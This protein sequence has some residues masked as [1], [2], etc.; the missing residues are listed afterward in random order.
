MKYTLD[1]ADIFD[2]GFFRDQNI[3]MALPDRQDF[4][5]S[6]AREHGRLWQQDVMEW[7]LRYI[8]LNPCVVDVG[9]Y[10]GNSAIWLARIAGAK[11]VTAIEP[12]AWSYSLLETNVRLNGLGKVIRTVNAA[13]WDE[14][15]TACLRVDSINNHA[16]AQ[17]RPVPDGVEP[18]PL[19]SVPMV[20]IDSVMADRKGKVNLLLLDMEGY[21]YRAI[22][23]ARKLV[24]SDRPVLMVTTFH[25]T[26]KTL[27]PL[28][29]SLRGY[30]YLMGDLAE[31]GYVAVG[32]SFST[33][34]Y[35]PKE[36][37]ED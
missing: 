18:D 5:Q 1:N 20:T 4:L 11:S 7:A 17:Y 30:I 6:F 16:A 27:D 8:P 29:D 32:K 22:R 23:G 12:D 37:L 26:T 33:T 25:Q 31:L 13:V 9:S 24:E 36:K 14:P 15:G 2:F 28:Y 10:V 3:K 35:M 21:D 34:V 19:T